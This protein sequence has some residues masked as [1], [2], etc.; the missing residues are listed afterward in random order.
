[1]EQ[2]TATQTCA[3]GGFGGTEAVRKL[4]LAHA[5]SSMQIKI[6]RK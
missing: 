3:G 4:K 2:A 1:M 6:T 5:V